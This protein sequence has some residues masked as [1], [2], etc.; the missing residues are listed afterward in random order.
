MLFTAE[1]V[2]KQ[3]STFLYSFCE[4]VISNN[5]LIGDFYRC[6]KRELIFKMHILGFL[7][8]YFYYTLPVS[9]LL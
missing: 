1:Y 2:K 6:I 5:K 7:L 8:D 4:I 9:I 3:L